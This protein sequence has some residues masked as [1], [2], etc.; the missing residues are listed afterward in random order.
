MVRKI[1]NTSKKHFEGDKKRENLPK[2][3]VL[4]PLITK[5]ANIRSMKG[6]IYKKIKNSF[7]I[8]YDFICV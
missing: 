5:Q 2:Q 6:I 1:A 4:S 8:L 3:E 7:V